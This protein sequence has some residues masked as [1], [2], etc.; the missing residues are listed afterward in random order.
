MSSIKTAI[1]AAVSLNVTSLLAAQTPD[2]EMHVGGGGLVLVNVK[3][4]TIR[5]LAR[6]HDLRGRR[7]V[8]RAEKNGSSRLSPSQDVGPLGE[9]APGVQA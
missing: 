4:A 9:N 3:E 8:A 2:I 1:F 7:R 6:Q 5:A